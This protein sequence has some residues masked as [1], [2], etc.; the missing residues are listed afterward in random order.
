MKVLWEE[1]DIKPGTQFG[2]PSIS[3]RSII[4]FLAAE[5]GNSRY[6]VV[7]L[8]DGMT[9]PAMTKHE[10]SIWLTEGGYQPAVLL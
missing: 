4:G 8:S 10:M 9:L 1:N 6:L 3:E 7:S 5:Q 2:K